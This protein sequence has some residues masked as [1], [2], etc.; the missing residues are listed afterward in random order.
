VRSGFRIRFKRKEHISRDSQQ[1]I[2]RRLETDSK[3]KSLVTKD[4]AEMLNQLHIKA[5]GCFIYLEIILDLIDKQTITLRQIKDIPGTL[6]GLWLWLA[7][8]LFGKSKYENVRSILELLI[9][10]NKPITFNLIYSSLKY[11]DNKL[12]PTQLQTRNCYHSDDSFC[13]SH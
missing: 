11:R 1:Y 12:T 2:L 8:K 6:S 9:A 10:F 5:S 3:L 4:S 13:V 7:Q